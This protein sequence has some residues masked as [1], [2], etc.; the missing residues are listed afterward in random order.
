MS[1]WNAQFDS[2][3]ADAQVLDA[4]AL[5]A[6][7]PAKLVNRTHR[8]VRHRAATMK[9]RRSYVRSLLV[10]LALCSVLLALV[11][12]GVWSG[13]YQGD[14]AEAIQDVASLAANDTNNRLI[15]SL[16]WFVPLVLVLL[17]A[18]WV[19][20]VQGRDNRTAR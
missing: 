14:A 8:V 11:A 13:L 10:P 2:E 19:R 3:M 7:A 4:R 6:A 12:F 15:V 20:R 18:V 16:A 17:V 1:T 5:S 9:A